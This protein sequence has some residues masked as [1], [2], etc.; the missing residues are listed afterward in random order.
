MNKSKILNDVK[1]NLENDYDSLWTIFSDKSK[2]RKSG[3]ETRRDAGELVEAILQSIFNSINKNLPQERKI[4]SLVGSSDRLS[5]TIEY[6]GK[7]YTESIQV[8]RHIWQINNRIAFVEN[9]TYLD[10]CYYDRALADFRKIAQALKQ[11]QIDPGD[12]SY[13]VFAGQKAASENTLLA[14]EADF[15]HDTK[16]LTSNP[17]GLVPQVYYFLQRTRNSQKPWN[18]NKFPLNHVGIEEFVNYILDLL[19]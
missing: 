6:K 18:E 5:K 17:N 10:S 14:Y 12:V 15:W 8:D 16:H 13:I 19:S 2:S 1:E 4:V 7:V 11:S 9:K 3:G